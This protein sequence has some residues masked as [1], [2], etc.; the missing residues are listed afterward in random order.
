ML[1]GLDS[2][3]CGKVLPR[4]ALR[5]GVEELTALRALDAHLTHNTE[6]GA[7]WRASCRQ[8][9]GRSLQADLFDHGDDIR[10][11]RVCVRTGYEGFSMRE[12][13]TVT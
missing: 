3:G 7:E 12:L 5:R 10:V 1:I 8:S 9:T 11:M 2:E 4:D 13:H 6:S